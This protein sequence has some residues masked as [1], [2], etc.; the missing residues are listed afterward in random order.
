MTWRARGWGW[1]NRHARVVLAVYWVWLVAMTHWP[2]LSIIPPKETPGPLDDVLKLD[3]VGHAGTFGL[4]MVLLILAGLGS[5]GRSWVGRCAVALG[6]G[7][8]FAVVDELTQGFVPGR[9][10]NAGDLLANL[11]AMLGV[12]VVAILPS[13][14]ERRAAPRWLWWTLI[15]SVPVL[16]LLALSPA[17][18]HQAL[19]W[20]AELLGKG[21]SNF[22]PVDH[23]IHGVLA[24]AL[25]VA[26]IVIWPMASARP[27]RAA[28]LA[29]VMLVGSAPAI[30]VAQ[31]FTGRS[32]EWQ[33]ELAHVIG[34]LLAM[35]WW[36]ARLSWSP[37][38]REPGRAMD[39]ARGNEALPASPGSVPATASG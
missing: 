7:V 3:K 5:R 34:V 11:V 20:K 36:A 13:A 21:R 16:A 28:V 17:V 24:S 10:V 19:V 22:H 35:M 30:E 6:V 18:M 2:N 27:R 14:R 38:L 1:L 31:H 23:I 4:L 37:T 9:T 12:Y 29:I 32:V 39:S 26:V 8:C 15:V 33:D 25:S